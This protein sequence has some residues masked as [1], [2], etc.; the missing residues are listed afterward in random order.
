LILA[1]SNLSP[2]VIEYKPLPLSSTE[3]NGT[4]C[5]LRQMPRKCTV[6][7][8]GLISE[9]SRVAIDYVGPVPRPQPGT[10]AQRSPACDLCGLSVAGGG[11]CVCL[12]PGGLRFGQPGTFPW[13]VC[14]LPCLSAQAV[15][16]ARRGRWTRTMVAVAWCYCA[17]SRP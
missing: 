11:F 3:P 15:F 7:I 8:A 17:R 10:S 12:R 6:I 14:V 4:E 13:L 16:F 9:G 2:L 1:Y 5:L